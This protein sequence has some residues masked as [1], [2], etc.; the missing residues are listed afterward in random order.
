MVGANFWDAPGHSMAGSN[1][2]AT[3]TL[4]FEWIARH[5][6]TFY[7]PR[8]PI[9]PVGVY[10][11]PKSRDYDGKNFL[12]SYRGALVALLQA[13][14]EF[15]VVT[16]RTLAGFRGESLVL[17]TVSYMNESENRDLRRFVDAGGRL[18]I[19]GAEP[20]GVP[21]SATAMRLAGDSTAAYFTAL[22]QDFA[23]GSGHPPSDFLN[24]VRRGAIEV[25]APPTLAANFALVNGSAH[26]FLAN[27]SGL[28]PGKVAVPT[29][30]KA[31]RVWLPYASDLRLT[32][33]PFLG[34]TQLLQ[35]E[36]KDD[37][38]EFVLPPVERG[39]AVW[40]GK[41]E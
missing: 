27:F 1:D 36:R 8:T 5:E 28:A 29:S 9:H 39:A 3:R 6:N 18:I 24:A 34:Q 7:A 11:S 2:P 30:V 16:P 15:Q 14:R 12:S 19:L 38:L 37:V 33:L 26:I 23:A 25:E 17:P 22:Q 20:A 13:H 21:L 4:I 35:G 10:F 32:F 41:G 31:I 40:V